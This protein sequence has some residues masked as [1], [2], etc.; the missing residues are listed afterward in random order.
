VAPLAWKMDLK[1]NQKFIV[2]NALSYIKNTGI[3]DSHNNL[4]CYLKSKRKCGIQYNQAK[5]EEKEG[6]K[7][8]FNELKALMKI[9]YVIY[10][11]LED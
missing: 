5:E 1:H 7:S 6:T 9:T 10:F 3:Q 11:T 8:E 2:Y 4:N